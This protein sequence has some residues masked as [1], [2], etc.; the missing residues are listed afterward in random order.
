M[1]YCRVTELRDCEL[2]S[3]TSGLI[4][5]CK[6]MLHYKSLTYNQVFVNVMVQLVGSL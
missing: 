1:T 2:C 6:G 3:E 4:K 5:G